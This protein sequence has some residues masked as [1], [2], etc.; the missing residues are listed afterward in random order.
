M[1]AHGVQTVTLNRL[2]VLDDNVAVKR[3]G[4]GTDELE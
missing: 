2:V 1:G 3:E 4:K